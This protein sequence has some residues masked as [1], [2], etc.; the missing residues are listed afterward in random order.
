MEAEEKE[1]LR[2]ARARGGG[3]ASDAI[4]EQ[5]E[6]DD[7]DDGGNDDDVAVDGPVAARSLTPV[8]EGSEPESGPEPRQLAGTLALCRS[9]GDRQ[10][11]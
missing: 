9:P 1:A 3:G 2:K 8:W 5:D 7:D 4:A 10:Q 6:L 11:R